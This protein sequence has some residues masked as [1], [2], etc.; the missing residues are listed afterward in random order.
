MDIRQARQEYEDLGIDTIPLRPGTKIAMRRNWQ[1]LDPTTLWQGV[2]DNANIGLR[3]GGFASIAFV[4]CDEKNQPGTYDKAVSWLAG[5]GYLPGDYPLIQ[6]ASQVGRQIYVAFAGGLPGHTRNLASEFGAGEFRYGPGAYVV[7]PPSQVGESVYI[8]IDGDYRQLPRLA[9]DDVLPIL[10]NKDITTDAADKLPNIPRRVRHMLDGKNLE[11]F[12]SRSEVEQSMIASLVN[13]GHSFD[14]VLNLFMRY[15]CAGKFAELRAKSLDNAVRWLRHCY[16]EAVKW[17]SKKDSKTRQT[18]AAML[19]WAMSIPWHGRTGPTDRA[20]FVAHCQ[21]AYRAGR[22]EYQASC[23]NLAELAGVTYPTASKATSRIIETGLVSI[24]TAAVA[25]LATRYRL[26]A[27]GQEVTLPNY[28]NGEG[29]LK[30]VHHHDAFR[31]G[32]K[33]AGMGK[34]AA[35]IWEALQDGPA[36]EVELAQRTGR[37][38]KTV[39]NHLRGMAMLADTVTGEFI[40]M[41]EKIGDQWRALDGVDLDHVAQV[42][43]TAG[44]GKRQQERHRQEQRAHRRAL[45]KFGEEANEV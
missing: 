14:S 2:Q 38:I 9:L 3:G 44:A 16:D 39:R 41:V 22:L 43:G 1:T 18:I 21:I 12:T 10:G 25:H 37:H 35:L 42:V 24:Q 11:G 5:L 13:A 7:A 30:F 31:K 34:S 28:S 45:E 26:N 8:L 32:A 19:E 23:R 33:N 4:D 20:V 6:T 27:A 40:P 36:T 15:P 29:V 17:T